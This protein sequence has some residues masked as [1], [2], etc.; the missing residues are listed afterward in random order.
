MIRGSIAGALL[1]AAVFLY[2]R[3][4]GDGLGSRITPPPPQLS[5]SSVASGPKGRHLRVTVRNHLSYPARG[6]VDYVVLGGET[7]LPVYRSPSTVTPRL[8]PGAEITVS[9]ALRTED[10]ARAEVRLRV[11]ERLAYFDEVHFDRS[12]ITPFHSVAIVEP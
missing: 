1:I 12:R 7:G 9:V 5:V 4:G 10:L 3:F 2:T 11:R 8:A 6:E